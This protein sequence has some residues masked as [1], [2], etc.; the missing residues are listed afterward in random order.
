MAFGIKLPEKLKTHFPRTLCIV[1]PIN[2]TKVEGP[3]F[4]GIGGHVW[5]RTVSKLGVFLAGRDR[6]LV[7]EEMFFSF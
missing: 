3:T 5:K 1:E 2:K 4:D 6:I 7:V